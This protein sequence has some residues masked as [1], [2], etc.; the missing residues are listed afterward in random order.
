MC[1]TTLIFAMYLLT[2]HS[3]SRSLYSLKACYAA[4]M[5]ASQITRNSKKPATR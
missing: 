3:N 4:S 1:N 2:C 5:T